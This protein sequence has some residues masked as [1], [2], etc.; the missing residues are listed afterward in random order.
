ML[1][2]SAPTFPV[3]PDRRAPAID[4][5]EIEAGRR[6]V[7]KTGRRALAAA[8]PRHRLTSS[9]LG[10]P[11]TSAVPGAVLGSSW[12][13]ACNARNVPLS[14]QAPGIRRG[15]FF[16]HLG[17]QQPAPIAEGSGRSLL[18][19]ENVPASCAAPRGSRSAARDGGSATALPRRSFWM[20][21]ART[22]PAAPAVPTY[23]SIRAR[24][25][26]GVVRRRLPPRPGRATHSRGPR[27]SRYN[28]S[29]RSPSSASCEACR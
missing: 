15:L 7:Q 20:S 19:L 27:P 22:R 24:P 11:I 8:P 29:R 17:S 21:F 10:Q 16:F 14:F 26:G 23:P 5:H 12:H 2:E 1:G 4:S 28:C 6:R 13:A 18:S 3:L 25:R 9:G